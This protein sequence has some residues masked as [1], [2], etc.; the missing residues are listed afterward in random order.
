M[1][2]VAV[3]GGAQNLFVSDAGL[4][5]GALRHPLSHGER[6][7]KTHFFLPLARERK[8]SQSDGWRV[9]RSQLNS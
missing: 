4:S 2:D 7:L 8:V 5:P 1:P 6:G 3:I 9:A